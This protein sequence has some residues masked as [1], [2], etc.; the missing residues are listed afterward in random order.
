MLR[1]ITVVNSTKSQN[2]SSAT[3]QAREHVAGVWSDDNDPTGQTLTWHIGVIVSIDAESVTTSYLQ[4]NSKDRCHC[5]YIVYPETA[6]TL[7]TPKDQI[8]A[9][10]DY[11]L[12]YLCNNQKMPNYKR[13]ND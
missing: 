4:S 8:I 2:S 5:V 9:T 11:L 1:E 7:C 12:V 10:Q 13:K 3:L 6:T